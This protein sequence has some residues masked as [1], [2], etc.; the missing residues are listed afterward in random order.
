MIQVL[1]HPDVLDMHGYVFPEKLAS[2]DLVFRW[3]VL[4]TDHRVQDFEADL[5]EPFRS[6]RI[7]RKLLRSCLCKIIISIDK[8]LFM[9][10][11]RNHLYPYFNYII[12]T[13][14]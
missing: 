10:Y 1:G 8:V 4:D 3:L 12:S 11:D 6:S 13:P 5:P 14:E 9:V 7:S 2:V